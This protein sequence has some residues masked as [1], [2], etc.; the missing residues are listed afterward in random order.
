M[1]SQWMPQV[2]FKFEVNLF[3]KSVVTEEGEVIHVVL[4]DEG[5]L[6]ANPVASVTFLVGL[7][8]GEGTRLGRTRRTGVPGLVGPT[9]T[10]C[11]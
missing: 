8:A 6:L 5:S 4:E 1:T 11:T 7:D 9:H 2:V 10:T 3:K